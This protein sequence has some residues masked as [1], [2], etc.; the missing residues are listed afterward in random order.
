MRVFLAGVMQASLP[1]K[2]IVDQSY[3]NAIGEA[4]LAKWSELD[5]IDPLVLHP[6]SVEYDDDAAR[7]TL[8]ALVTLASSC[9]LLIAYVPQASM[10]T[11]LE[12]NAAYEAGVPVIAISPLRENW[13]IRALAT[14]LFPDL[15]T[16]RDYLSKLE[17]PS[18]LIDIE[19]AER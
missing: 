16:F 9:D 12:M 4:L 10:G 15:D 14:R 13:V 11:A 7:E 8:F 19:P 5:V 18:E 1:G 2:G 17:K 6:N 3:R